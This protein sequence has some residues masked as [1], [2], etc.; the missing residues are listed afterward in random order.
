MAATAHSSLPS[1]ASRIAGQAGAERQQR[2]QI[3]HQDAQRNVPE[4][5]AHRSG[6]SGSKGENGM[7]ANIARE[8]R[9]AAMAK[10]D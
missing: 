10:R 4:A 7:A 9:S 1:I 2:D 3:G 8:F 5:A 6:R